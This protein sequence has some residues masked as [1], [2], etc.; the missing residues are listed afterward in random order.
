MHIGKLGQTIGVD[1][2]TIRYYEKTRLLPPPARQTNGY[3]VYG[4][5]HVERLAF[6]RHCRALDMSLADVKR[7]LDFVARPAADCSD[8]D[9]LIDEQLIRVRARLKS[10]RAL[11][12][13]LA[14]LRRQCE[15]KRTTAECG[16]LNELVSAAH[17]ESCACHQEASRPVTARGVRKKPNQMLR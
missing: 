3:R 2:E 15:V 6:I 9:R 13:Q 16:I 14:V 4:K 12:R 1:I 17:G 8:V 10:L 7:L 11:E 5:P